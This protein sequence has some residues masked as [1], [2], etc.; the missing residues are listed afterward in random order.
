MSLKSNFVDDQN[1]VSNFNNSMIEVIDQLVLA[2]DIQMS[3]TQ[4][5]HYI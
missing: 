5:N 2:F 4:R 3:G 1:L